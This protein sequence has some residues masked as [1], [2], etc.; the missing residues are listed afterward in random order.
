ML[1]AFV[2]LLLLVTSAARLPAATGRPEL[3]GTW[4]LERIDGVE[5]ADAPPSGYQNLVV[6]FSADGRMR[7]WYPGDESGASEGPYAVADGQLHGWMGLSNDLDTPRRVETPAEGWLE[8]SFPDGFVATFRK[9]DADR[10]LT[11]HC[12]FFTVVGRDYDAEQVRRFK[13]AMFRFR[14]Q[15]VPPEL[16]GAW[17]AQMGQA[18]YGSVDLRIEIDASAARFVLRSL[19]PAEE[20]LSDDREP[21]EV[22]GS[23]LRSRALSCGAVQRYAVVNGVLELT[24]SAERPLRLGRQE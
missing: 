7:F 6:R 13:E 12:V 2:P 22:S 24:A 21:L 19:E 9:A 8:I 18:G 17:Q 3:L 5:P 1:K 11:P 23:F 15:P 16:L 20:V 4:E 14:P 10:D